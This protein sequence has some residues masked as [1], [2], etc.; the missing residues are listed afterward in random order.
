MIQPPTDNL[1]KF[2]AI[3]GLII[4]I[5]GTISANQSYSNWQNYLI[6]DEFKFAKNAE[7][8]VLAFKTRMRILDQIGA[9]WI[10]S[11]KSKLEKVDIE[12]FNE[13]QKQL[14]SPEINVPLIDTIER[15]KS[16]KMGKV[17]EDKAYLMF[18]VAVLSIAIG[19]VLSA[20]GFYLW[21]SRVQV[22]LDAKLRAESQQEPSTGRNE[23]ETGDAGNAGGTDA[24]ESHL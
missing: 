2:L 22:F 18:E 10:K 6:D 11:K 23:R 12:N 4:I 9:I 20:V 19:T 17:L 3:F 16:Q 21:Y 1:Y 8:S 7:K 24:E 15:K 14:A 13:L 5:T